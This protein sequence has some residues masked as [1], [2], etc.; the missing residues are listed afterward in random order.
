MEI[1][2]KLNDYFKIQNHAQSQRLNEKKTHL[3]V[4]FCLLLHI[5]K[6]ERMVE[7]NVNSI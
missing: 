6:D 1:V 7:T 4:D 2:I 3:S 5:I